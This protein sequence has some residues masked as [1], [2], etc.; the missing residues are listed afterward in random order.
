MT[1]SMYVKQQEQCLNAQIRV[2]LEKHAVQI[3]DFPLIPMMVSPRPFRGPHSE[4][5]T[6]P[7]H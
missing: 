5:L 7:R 1:L 3:P 2:A 4:Y 6:S